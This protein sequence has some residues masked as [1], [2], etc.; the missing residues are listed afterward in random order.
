MFPRSRIPRRTLDNLV[1]AVGFFAAGC[2]VLP[3]A[4]PTARQIIRQ[5]T[6]DGNAEPRFVVV[7][8]DD[9]VVTA[10]NAVPNR[11]LQ[12]RFHPHGVPPEPRIGVGDSIII[13]I[14]EAA[15]GGL[16]SAAPA[17]HVVAGSHSVTL[18]EQMVGRDGA[19]TVP[20][21]GRIPVAGRLPVEV[22]RAIEQRLAGKAIE[23]QAIVTV[24]KSTSSTVTVSGEVV[25]GARLPLSPKGDRILDL[26]AAAGGARAPVYETFVRLSRGDATV[27]VPMEILVS[28]P[29]ENIYAEPGDVLTIVRQ[30]QSFTAFGAAGQN[31]QIDFPAARLMLVEALAKAGGLQDA[32]SDPAG[33]FLFRWEPPAIVEALGRKPLPIGP[34]GA[35][36]VIYRLNLADAR[37]YFLAGRFPVRDKDVLYVANADVNEFQKFLLLLNTATAPVVTGIVIR[38]AAP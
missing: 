31:T 14:W 3:T 6:S 35:S 18:P 24:T 27:T 15:D 26:I 33:V 2:G 32:R 37:S 23:P 34:D 25:S 8:V 29:A 10:L 30:P 5:E 28:D 36:P 4:G 11:T 22:Q 12:T 13:S 7:D 16:F 17:E 38:N 19:I 21:A 20:F 9:R 1:L